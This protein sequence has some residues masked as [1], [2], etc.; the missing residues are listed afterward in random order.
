MCQSN[1]QTANFD[2]CNVFSLIR[3]RNIDVNI[4]AINAQYI[5]IKAYNN[6]NIMF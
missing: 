1:D 6:N 3:E 5:N 2:P 4:V